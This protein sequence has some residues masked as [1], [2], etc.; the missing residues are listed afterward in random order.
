MVFIMQY[1]YF[2]L[3][4]S[5]AL[6]F[7]VFA[8]DTPVSV[9]DSCQPHT[10]LNHTQ[11]HKNNQISTGHDID[12]EIGSYLLL[13][14]KSLT[15]RAETAR[16]AK[17]LTNRVR[18][19]LPLSGGDL[20]T[21]NQGMVAHL[22]LRH[23]LY[24]VAYAH[25]C[26][27]YNKKIVRQHKIDDYSQLKGIMLSLTAALM[28]YDN[29]LLSISIF[30][31]NDKLRR[32]LNERDSGY[33]IGFAQL[34]EV[35]QSYYSVINRARV[36]NAINFYERKIKKYKHKIAQDEYFRFLY[37][38]IEQSPSYDMTREWSPLYVLNNHVKLLSTVSV[39]TFHNIAKEGVNLFSLIFGNTMGLVETRKGKL[40]DKPSVEGIVEGNLK[41]GDI[42]LEKTPFRLTDTVIPGHWG[43]AA[44]WVGTEMELRQ[45]GIWNHPV[46]KEYHDQLRTGYIIV[47]A[48][49]SGVQLSDLKHFLNVDD[50][51]VLRDA[52]LSKQQRAEHIIRALRQVGKSYD[53]NFDVE[54]TDRIVCSELIYAVFTNIQWPTERT[55]GRNT[56]SPDHVAS[57]ALSNGPLSLVLFYHDGKL[58]ERQPLV[59]MA[60]LVRGE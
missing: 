16:V 6:S 15:Y 51:A 19:G 7:P 42:L 48:L 53:F 36:R 2:I 47:E 23:Q 8:T 3:I 30:E 9:E 34:L 59:K 12:I 20:D 26:W 32:I 45:L 5:A 49:R 57:K 60:G 58:V 14:E 4:L 46:V 10:K 33:N 38:L 55:L 13:V 39:D 52:F 27:L 24:Q 25:E 40:Y 22:G 35:T 17:K 21:L 29:Y 1:L 56:I 43:H 37:T 31:E 28:L 18:L 54:T 44:I 11:K 41:A 50:V